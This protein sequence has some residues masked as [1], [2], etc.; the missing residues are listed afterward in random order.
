MFN[1]KK[2]IFGAVIIAIVVIFAVF[3]FYNNVNFKN[4]DIKIGVIVP[5][6]GD[7]ANVA[8]DVQFGVRLFAGNHSEAKFVIENDE[9]D[10]KKQSAQ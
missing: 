10:T 5:L 4:S 8:E 1:K 7:V 2:Y 3:A 9:G 6:S